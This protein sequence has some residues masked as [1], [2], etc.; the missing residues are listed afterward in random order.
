MSTWDRADVKAVA[1]APGLY[2][3]DSRDDRH[4]LEQI[5]DVL[6]ACQPDLTEAGVRIALGIAI[7]ALR[8]P[9][10]VGHCPDCGMWG[11]RAGHMFCQYPGR[12]TDPD[13]RE[14]DNPS[15][16]GLALERTRDGYSEG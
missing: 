5:R 8:R 4:A 16:T 15:E 7:G 1:I 11:E 10:V 6:H 14:R 2:T 3:P 12:V 13:A 9:D